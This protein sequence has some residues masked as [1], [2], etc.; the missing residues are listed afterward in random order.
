MKVIENP[1]CI[2]ITRK[3]EQWENKE[4]NENTMKC[5]YEW[6]VQKC[7]SYFRLLFVLFSTKE[8]NIYVWNLRPECMCTH[9]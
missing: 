8:T 7:R 9:G 6:N 3:S 1:K 4:L 5:K 2:Q